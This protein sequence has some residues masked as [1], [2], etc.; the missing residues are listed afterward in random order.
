MI[1]GRVGRCT[2]V[3]VPAPPLHLTVCLWGTEPPSCSGKMALG[4]RKQSWEQPLLPPTF[5]QAQR[6]SDRCPVQS[7]GKK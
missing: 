5:L 4:A 3:T 7:S 6:C 1:R 2:E